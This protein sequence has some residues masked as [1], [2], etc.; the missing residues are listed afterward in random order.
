MPHS[1]ILNE[2]ESKSSR[3]LILASVASQLPS[4]RVV[5]ME[6][7]HEGWYQI[8]KETLVL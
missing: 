1:E 6:A 5:M 7:P 4:E 2:A 8:S 3:V